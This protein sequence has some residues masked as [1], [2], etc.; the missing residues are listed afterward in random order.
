MNNEYKH[1]T[2]SFPAVF[3]ANSK[4]LI[5]G[6]VPSV[7]SREQGFFYMHPQNRFWKVLSNIFNDDFLGDILDKKAK[8]L[9]HNI[10]LYD[11]IESCDIIGSSDL[12]IKNVE[13]AYEVINRI[14]EKA[15]IKKIVLN[16]SKAA[17]LFKKY[18]NFE[19]IDILY[20]PSTSPANAKM[21]IDDLII[22]W[23]VM[24]NN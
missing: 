23:K 12:S 22:A 8:L 3:D 5:L 15:D 17:T 4:V 13:P 1:I 24:I 6:S 11:V 10:A 16:G 18:F 9:K 21:N 2:H 19:G 7:K 14:I 20:M